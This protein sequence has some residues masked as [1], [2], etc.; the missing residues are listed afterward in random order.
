MRI[1]LTLA[2]SAACIPTSLA[3][4][5][6]PTASTATAGP[7][8][9]TDAEAV[10]A[11]LATELEENFVFPDVAK[12]YASLL[13]AKLAAGAYARFAD[14]S[15]FA[16]AV[17][18]DLQAV[19]PDKHLRLYAPRPE[20][21]GRQPQ[22]GGPP[23]GLNAISKS[24]WLAPGVAY[25]RFEGF[26]GNKTTLDAVR[27]FIAD[28]ANAKTLIIDARSHRGGGLAEMDLLFPHLF[29]KETVLVGM[30][31]RVAVDERGGSPI[32]DE[33]VRKIGG[34]AGVVRR[35]HYVT[36]ASPQSSLATAKIYLLVSKATG[37]AGEHLALAL[38]RTGRAT[39]IG[40]TT[41]GM[42]H[43]GG[44]VPI[45]HGYRAF[46]PVGRTFDPDTNQGWEG[47]G[48][49]P[50]VEVA[51]EKALDEALRLAGVNKSGD[52]ALAQLR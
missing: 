15:A 48:V 26:P 28:H 31:T 22:R 23:A 50:N 40:E 30:D 6:A 35:E 1:Q 46:I 37:S 8:V 25:V 12:N 45:A 11:K 52:A 41:R 33:R 24:G 44:T 20:D 34:P 16:D 2:L 9:K 21:S 14:A 47:T 49:K 51:A 19:H 4:Q 36:P 42:G 32:I 38:K 43:Y 10:V 13:R 39:L 18:A 29:A 7:F 27:A 17:T 3:A 5:T